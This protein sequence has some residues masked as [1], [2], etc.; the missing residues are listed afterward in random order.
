M[1]RYNRPDITSKEFLLT[2]MHD[3]SLPIRMRVNAAIALLP[4][5]AHAPEPVRSMVMSEH[6]VLHPAI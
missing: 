5:I 2:V 1:D 4:Y 3:P 6:D